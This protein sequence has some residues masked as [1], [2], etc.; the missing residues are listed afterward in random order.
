MTLLIWFHFHQRCG[1]GRLSGP[2]AAPMLTNLPASF[3]NFLSIILVWLPT[4][5]C[6]WWVLITCGSGTWCQLLRGEGSCTRLSWLSSGIFRAVC[7]LR[8]PESRA[9]LALIS[10]C[11]QVFSPMMMCMTGT[12]ETTGE[13]EEEIQIFPH[14]KGRIIFQCLCLRHLSLLPQTFLR[15]PLYFQEF[16]WFRKTE[17]QCWQCVGFDPLLSLVRL[18]SP[19]ETL[20]EGALA[21]GE[22]LTRRVIE[23]C[24]LSSLHFQF[25][26]YWMDE[27]IN[28]QMINL[29][30]IFFPNIWGGGWCSN[31]LLAFTET[32]FVQWEQ[33]LK[34]Y[35]EMHFCFYW[36]SLV[37]QLLKKKKVRSSEMKSMDW[38]SPLWRLF[39]SFEHKDK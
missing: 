30:N 14:N 11:E 15:T 13:R 21:H 12:G 23:W 9:D 33:T 4:L 8:Y 39:C 27:W 37:F 5:I 32:E 6:P 19:Q 35:T 24:Y 3:H 26:K 31:L 7:H 16:V 18:T 2:L 1:G 22:L 20:K 10:A 28:N 36:P 34:K 25:V 29:K 38:S 17:E